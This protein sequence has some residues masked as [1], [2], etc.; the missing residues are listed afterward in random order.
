MYLGTSL[1]GFA[2]Y[3]GVYSLTVAAV[4]LSK[5]VPLIPVGAGSIA[6]LFSNFILARHVVFS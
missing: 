2:F 4:P 6:G 3:F 5:I 1:I